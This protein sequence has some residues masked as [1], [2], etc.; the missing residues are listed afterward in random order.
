MECTGLPNFWTGLIKEFMGVI[1]AL[2]TGD[3]FKDL[4]HVFSL[5]GGFQ[6]EL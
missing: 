6:G 4:G 3:D 5:V 1:P 2:V